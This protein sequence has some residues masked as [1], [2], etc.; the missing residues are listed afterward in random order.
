[1]L[2][3]L[4]I[5]APYI[6]FYGPIKF[7]AGRYFP[8]GLGYIASFLRQKG[9]QILLYE[10]E[11]QNMDYKAIGRVLS[12]ERP[13]VVGISSATPNFYNAVE[14]AKLA[15]SVCNCT[16]VYGGVHASAMPGFIAEKYHE[17]FDYV[18]AG[19][20]EY[21]IAEL[22]E[23]LKNKQVPFNIPGLCFWH[24]GGIIQTPKR[25]QIS[26]IDC[27]P[28]PARDLIPQNLFGPNMHNT[29]YKKCF[30]IL[31]SRGCPFNCSFCASYL[32]MGKKYR[33][34][35]AEYVLGEISF[36]KRQYGAEQLIIND[37]T[38]T[39]DQKRLVDICEGMIKRGLNLKWFCFSQ[40]SAIDKNIL[41]L[42]HRAGCYNIGFGIE[43]ASRRIL[44][45]IGKPDFLEK[46]EEIIPAANDLGMKTQAFFV[47]G[48]QDETI[49]DIDET[50]KF[51][52]R[53]KPT[54]S[55]F[56]MLVP[57]PGT[58]DFNYFFKDTPLNKIDWK[59][60]VAIGTKS[61]VSKASGNSINLEK[62][63][64]KANLK[65]YFRPNQLFHLLSKIKTLYELKC[66]VKGGM[67]LFLQMLAWKTSE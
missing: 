62:M 25:P 43:S 17:Y 23:C 64:Y 30:T 21:T 11:A 2:K 18:V 47:F 37:D 34:H 44:K 28:Y 4:L 58:R 49:Q 12:E 40:I 41:K 20:G 36:L 33:I 27:L 61:V 67:G 38:F 46:C 56:N 52:I 48:K 15:K 31:T 63:L 5:S 6:D 66:Y 55:F 10:P 19:E 16:V 65:F 1:M 24:D 26:D 60:F 45:L 8:L 14:L 13:D 53:L 54:L 42:M 51:A 29:R 50:V 32:T 39:L 57:Y 22:L 35:S 59:K 3:V 7:A 9:F